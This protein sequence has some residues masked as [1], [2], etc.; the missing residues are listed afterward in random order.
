MKG[1]ISIMA[2]AI[3][4]TLISTTLFAK[5]ARYPEFGNGRVEQKLV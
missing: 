2:V 5:E 1:S 4:L 3:S